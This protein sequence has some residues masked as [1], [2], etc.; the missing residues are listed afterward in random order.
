[1]YLLFNYYLITFIRCVYIS[2]VFHENVHYTSRVRTCKMHFLHPSSPDC[3]KSELDLFSMNPTQISVSESNFI[4]INPLH[5]ITNTD[6]PLEFNIP[7][8]SDQYLDPSNVFL[9]VKTKLTKPDGT[10]LPSGDDHIVYTESN[11]LYT[12]FTPVSYTHLRAH[13]T[14]EHLVCRLL[15]EKKKKTKKKKI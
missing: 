12:C 1:M 9:Y 14:P 11:F 4:S 8:T 6:V 15:L 3:C 10:D 7:G 13:E 5:S 2:K